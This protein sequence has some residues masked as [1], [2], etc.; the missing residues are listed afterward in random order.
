MESHRA[1]WTALAA[2]SN[3]AMHLLVDDPPP[4]LRDEWALRLIGKEA[5]KALRDNAAAFRTREWAAL[6]GLAV[7]RNRHAED[8]LGKAI[9][10]GASQYV[11]LG[12]GLDSFAHREPELAA[13][14]TVFEVDHP[15]SQRTKR[16]LLSNI[17]APP[18]ASLRYAPVDFETETL[19]ESLS[20]AGFHRDLPTFFSWLGVTVYLSDSA[21]FSTLDFVRQCAAG[22]EIVFEYSL[23]LEALP[24]DEQQLLT[25]SIARCQAR[26]ERFESFFAPAMLAGRLEGLGFSEIY[27]FEPAQAHPWYLA[28]RSDSLWFSELCHLMHASVAHPT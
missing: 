16:E 6:R 8:L 22:T 17:G 1:S 15:A 10:R 9:E 18:V 11:L 4:I 3:R 24:P 13:R 5:A 14:L 7:I 12:A 28:G 27:D 20:R 26:G 2:A 21:S 23:P 25:A 19:G